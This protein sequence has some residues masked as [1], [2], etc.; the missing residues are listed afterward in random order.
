MV[1]FGDTD[2]LRQFDLE[3]W[4][5]KVKGLLCLFIAGFQTPGL[6]AQFFNMAV[7]P[8]SKDGRLSPDNW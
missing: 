5:Q 4:K 8:E 3:E 2:I 6:R 1:Y 7:K